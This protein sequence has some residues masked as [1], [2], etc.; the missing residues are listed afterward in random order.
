MRIDEELIDAV[1]IG[2]C[3][4]GGGGGG[5]P[6]AGR[7]MGRLALEIGL[8]RLISLDE[9]PDDAVIV[10]VSAVGAPAAV[11]QF[12]TPMNYVHALE[13]LRKDLG[14]VD[15]LITSENGGLASTN[16][17]FQS[18]VTGIPV[19]DA[20][21][22]GR[23]HPTGM[24]GAIGLHK[25]AGYVSR[26][27]A[28]GGN[29]D[30]GMYT[31][32]ITG[33]VISEASRLVRQ[34]A[35]SAGGMVAVARNPVTVSYVR[36]HAAPGALSQA[37]DVGRHM[38]STIDKN[39][40]DTAKVAADFLG[41]QVAT[42]GIVES[43]DLETRNGFDLGTVFIRADGDLFE[44]SFWNEYMTLDSGG[45][46]LATFP[47]LIATVEL[48]TGF[49]LPTAAIAKGKRVAVVTVPK[50]RLILGAG[51][52]DSKLMEEAEQIVDRPMLDYFLNGG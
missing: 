22:N 25:E 13:L 12:C 2:G 47:D 48:E 51:M 9:L 15:G 20:P 37:I 28:A 17:W 35:V 38:L 24:M 14:R 46:R 6:T 1:V 33:A 3:F 27:A 10:T 34:A 29:P 45:K 21:C 41:G 30:L 43:I 50:S 16:G 39:T 52:K 8:P 49:P 19:V 40:S 32:I 26:Q 42:E 31:E 44:L 7:R 36:T 11:D 23:A 5:D 18:A 4:L